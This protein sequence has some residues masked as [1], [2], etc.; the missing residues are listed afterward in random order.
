ME[1]NVK[2]CLI[3]S[4]AKKIWLN[5]QN[6]THKTGINMKKYQ[7][8]YIIQIDDI[9]LSLRSI[10]LNCFDRVSLKDFKILNN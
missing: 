5:L 1:K 9:T 3:T 4:P 6:I 10:T 2:N 7:D 8:R